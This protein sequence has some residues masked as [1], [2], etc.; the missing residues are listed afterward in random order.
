MSWPKWNGCALLSA[1]LTLAIPH[2][3]HRTERFN[4]LTHLRNWGHSRTNEQNNEVRLSTPHSGCM[5]CG[6]R[7]GNFVKCTSTFDFLSF[8]VVS[9][10]SLPYC[11]V[12]FFRYG[13][14]PAPPVVE[15]NI[16]ILFIS[17]VAIPLHSLS[18]PSPFVRPIAPLSFGWHFLNFPSHFAKPPTIAIHHDPHHVPS[19]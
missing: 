2:K 7:I 17:F 3:P 18:T 6:M 16:R 4:R 12:S 19:E 15:Y 5:H 11:T 9:P 10:L 14:T 13:S 1:P 8:A